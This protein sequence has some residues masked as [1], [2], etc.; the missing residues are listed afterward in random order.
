MYSGVFMDPIRLGIIGTGIAAQQL[1][2]PALEKLT[3][4]IRIIMVCNHT[5]PKAKA[6][7]EMAGGV[8]YCLDYHKLLN[9]PD[10]EAVSISLPIH[11][12]LGVTR[13]A[14][15]AGKH[16][17]V[18]KP[19]AANLAEAGEMRS[20]PDSHPGLVAMVGENYR[21]R[22]L[23]RTLRK[24]IEDG[25]IG[26]PYSVLWNYLI[27]L[28]LEKNQYARTSWRQAPRHVG[29]FVTDAGVHN[30]AVLRTLAGEFVSGRAFTAS[31]LPAIG[32]PDTFSLQ[33]VT[34]TGIQ[35]VL[36]LYFRACGLWENMMHVFGNRGTISAT[37]EQF[38]LHREGQPDLVEDARDGGG[39]CEEFEAFVRAIREGETVESTFGEAYRDLEILIK[40]IEAAEDGEGEVTF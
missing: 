5:E 40:A 17:I 29:G 36:N 35:G 19:L 4:Q 32:K 9:N 12:N 23:Y 28:D 39:Y 21:Y 30:I 6:F 3:E 37:R 15:E 2:W 27:Q 13:E 34:E 22:P 14:L 18:E 26:Q 20:L 24:L 16:V 7:S 10:V 8:P 25:A 31:I 11:L 38:T 33:F 1:H